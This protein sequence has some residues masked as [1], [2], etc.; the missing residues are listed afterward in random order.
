[1][2]D[3]DGPGSDILD[4]SGSLDSASAVAC[5]RAHEATSGP[6]D[7]VDEAK[8]SD[9]PAVEAAKGDSSEPVEETKDNGPPVEE[10]V[11][12]GPAKAEAVNNAAAPV[13]SVANESASADSA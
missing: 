7:R 13:A 2:Y 12:N 8:E 3:S 10:A 5:G 1:M 11:A 6:A 4:Q 9:G